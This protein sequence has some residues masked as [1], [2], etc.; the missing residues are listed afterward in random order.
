MHK[1]YW[2]WDFEKQEKWLNEMS[3]KGLQLIGVGFCCK[4][5]FE[6]G[7]PGEYNY[8]IELL[9]KN[10]SHPESIVYIH[11]IEDTGIEHIGAADK[12]VYF[13]KKTSDGMFDLFS[14]LDSRISHLKRI[15]RL[16][17]WL[18]PL[19]IWVLSSNILTAIKLGSWLNVIGAALLGVI[20]V[21]LSIETIKIILKIRHL[22]NERRMRE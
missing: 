3:A 5:V 20:L 18:F 17:L 16:F 6:E 10:P 9:K 4:Y 21:L 14:D 19:E 13:R 8:H 12:W 1:W 7:T 22:K 2:A 15:R 11:F